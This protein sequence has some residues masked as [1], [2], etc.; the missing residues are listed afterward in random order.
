MTRNAVIEL[1]RIKDIRDFHRIARIPK[2][3]L[4]NMMNFEVCFRAANPARRSAFI[5]DK[6]FVI[7]EQFGF[8]ASIVGGN[9]IV[10]PSAPIKLSVNKQPLFPINHITYKI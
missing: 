10:L 1:N 3:P 6:P 5:P 9:P 2:R 8:P 4:E 7:L